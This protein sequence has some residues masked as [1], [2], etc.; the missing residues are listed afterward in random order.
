MLYAQNVGINTDSPDNSALLDLTSTEKGLLPPRMNTAQ[1]KDVA[2]PA[3]GLLVY[4]TDSSSFCVYTGSSWL[5]VLLSTTTTAVNYVGTSYLGMTSGYGST[6]AKEGTSS[7]LY[8]I[9]IGDYAGNANT[10]GSNNIALGYN[11]LKANTTNTDQVAIG[12]NA[13]QKVIRTYYAGN[14]AGSVAIGS[15]ALS[16]ATY[17]FGNVAIGESAI[18]NATTPSF[19]TA[20]GYKSLSNLTTGSSNAAVGY[21]ALQS[22]GVA[23]GSTALGAYSLQASTADNNVG[24]G[25]FTGNDNTTGD[26]N[27]YIGSQSGLGNTTGK[28]N[29]FIGYSAVPSSSDLKYAAA[30]GAESVVAQ[31]STI[32]LGADTYSSRNLICKVGIGTSSPNSTLGV[33]GSESHK[34]N[35]ITNSNNSIT[36]GSS[37]Y[38][39]I[40]SGSASGNSI[41]LPAASTCSGR[42]YLIVNHSSNDVSLSSNYYTANNITSATVAAGDTVQLMSD[43]SSSWHKIN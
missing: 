7:N 36:L 5:K 18:S 33:N 15:N 19:N 28:A 34:V 37:D 42:V 38:S 11:A 39:I 25:Y 4:N 29:T 23:I 17:T 10:S 20:V 14:D 31:D 16:S 32:V 26:R 13:M 6:G 12:K 8:N 24:V 40:Y 9:A 43:G 22:A 1:M 27:T 35:L 30:I 2:S 21:Q 3:A 41:S